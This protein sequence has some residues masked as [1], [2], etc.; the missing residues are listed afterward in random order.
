MWFSLILPVIWQRTER[1]GKRKTTDLTFYGFVSGYFFKK[2]QAAIVWR[3]LMYD[4]PSKHT[5]LLNKIK[6]LK[7]NSK[8]V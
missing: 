7:I 3:F 2:I 5:P 8:A 1:K 6:I 4:L